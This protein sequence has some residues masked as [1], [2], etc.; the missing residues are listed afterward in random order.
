MKTAHISLGTVPGGQAAVWLINLASSEPTFYFRLSACRT[1]ANGFHH[2]HMRS[3][4]PVLRAS[5]C[6]SVTNVVPHRS[7]TAVCASP[8]EVRS[9]MRSAP[10]SVGLLEC[11]IVR[12]VNLVRAA[13]RPEELL[14]Y[15]MD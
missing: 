7:D 6:G 9:Q 4:R 5:Y 12:C 3:R 14:R 15:L 8:P 10:P 13:G 11:Q 1:P 2:M